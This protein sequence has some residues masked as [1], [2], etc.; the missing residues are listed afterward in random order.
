MAIDINRIRNYLKNFNFKNL[1]IEELGWDHCNNKL[2]ISLDGSSFSLSAVAEKHGMVAFTSS[3]SS[4]GHIPHYSIRRKIE[5][6]AA[7]SVHEHII[8]YTDNSNTIQIWQWV[9]RETGKPT[10]CREH[11]YH[12]NQP[13]DSLI[14]KL[15]SIVFSLEEEETL[16]I[17]EVAGHAKA[18]FDV[19]RITKRFYDRFKAEH[20]AFLKFMPLQGLVWVPPRCCGPEGSLLHAIAA[21]G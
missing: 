12:V 5:R 19:E 17:V 9:K 13:G 7:K 11:A 15:Q 16:T 8:I 10:A 3:P 18:A 1:F 2:D 20:D 4:D 21:L 6:Q 14:Q